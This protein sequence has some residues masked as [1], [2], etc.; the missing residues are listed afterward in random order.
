MLQRSGVVKA[1]ARSG[2]PR[3][4]IFIRR[5]RAEVASA[6][7]DAQD[8]HAF[9]VDSKRNAHAPA[10][11]DHAQSFGNVIAQNTALGE[12][13]E[14]KAVV[15]NCSNKGIGP[16]GATCFG[17]KVVKF[18]EFVNRRGMKDDPMPHRLAA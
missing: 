16:A 9:P 11:T 5:H 14:A 15:A 4:L 8:H 1:Q 10:K 13:L 17:D 12:C 2:K 7:I 3:D 18:R 6:V